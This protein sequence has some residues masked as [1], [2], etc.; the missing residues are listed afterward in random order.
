L[1]EAEESE[2]QWRRWEEKRRQKQIELR[3]AERLQHLRE[4]G[5]PTRQA[6]ELRALIARVR[7]PAA[8]LVA[9]DETQLAAWEAW[10]SAEADR[11]D[12][13]LFRQILTHLASPE[14]QGG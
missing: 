8:D 1:R 5:D 6:G 3:D 12:P 13:I 14:E 7:D 10:A 4:S 9:V 11:L 2:E